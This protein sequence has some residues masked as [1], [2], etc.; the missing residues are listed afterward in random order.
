MKTEM[1]EAGLSAAKT[2][3]QEAACRAST[4]LYVL[5]SVDGTGGLRHPEQRH[6]RPAGTIAEGLK[7]LA[8]RARARGV[9]H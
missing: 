2:L 8:E 7:Q 9:E 1:V 4:S 3:V 5:L 6:P